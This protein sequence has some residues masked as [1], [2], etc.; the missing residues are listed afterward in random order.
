MQ[1][2]NNKLGEIF[3]PTLPLMPTDDRKRCDICPYAA[4][5]GR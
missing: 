4:L 3:D 1:Q 5:C 2:L